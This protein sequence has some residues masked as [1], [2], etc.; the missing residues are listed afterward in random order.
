MFNIS[1]WITIACLQSMC[2]SVV[3]SASCWATNA[4]IDVNECATKGGTSRAGLCPG[5]KNIRCCSW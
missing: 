5:A 3:D 4:C 1:L 2:I